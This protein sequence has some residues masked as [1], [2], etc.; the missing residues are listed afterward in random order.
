[1]RTYLLR[2]PGACALVAAL[3][4]ADLVYR[5]AVRRPLRVALGVAHAA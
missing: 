5:L 2:H 1:M 3:A 4:A